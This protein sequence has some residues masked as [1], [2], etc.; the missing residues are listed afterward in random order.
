LYLQDVVNATTIRARVHAETKALIIWRSFQMDDVLMNINY[1][2]FS[3]V[4]RVAP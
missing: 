4:D 2:G 3:K 1:L